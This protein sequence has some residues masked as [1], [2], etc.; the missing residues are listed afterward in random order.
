M[1]E[2]N[3]EF[4]ESDF[5]R[6]NPNIAVFSSNRPGGKGGLDLWT[7]ELKMISDLP[8]EPELKLATSVSEIEVTKFRKFILADKRILEYSKIPESRYTKVNEN[9]LKIYSDSFSVKPNYLEITVYPKF[10]KDFSKVEVK[11]Q[12]ETRSDSFLLENTKETSITKLIDLQKIASTYVN[13]NNLEISAAIVNSEDIH[14]AE[15]SKSILMFNSTK[16][17]PEEVRINGNAFSVNIICL[18]KVVN[19]MVLA[20]NLELINILKTKSPSQRKVIIESSPTFDLTGN[21]II[22]DWCKKAFFDYKDIL[23]QKNIF[24]KL[25]DY[26][27]SSD[28]N[29]LLILIQI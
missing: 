24:P 21:Q 28:F 1:S 26:L 13:S 4:D 11:L 27:T 12:S 6:I 10:A 7:S 15:K 2:F 16:E 5:I 25:S 29:Y 18:P 14:L 3:T 23:F 8:E 9:Y 22:R 20:G 17:L 19:D